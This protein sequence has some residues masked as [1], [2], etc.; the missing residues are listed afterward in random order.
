M[1]RFS[2]WISDRER[3]ELDKRARRERTSVNWVVREA[4]REYLGLTNE[5]SEEALDETL[6]TRNN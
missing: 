5:D 2:A 6:V 1:V 4:I 3:S